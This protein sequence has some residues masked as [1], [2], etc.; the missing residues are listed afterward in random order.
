MCFTFVDDTDLLAL[1]M[2]D[3]SITFD[4]IA[5]IIQEAIDRWEGGLKTMDRAIVPQ[6]S[7]VYALDFNFDSNGLPEIKSVD[8]IEQEFYVLDHENVRCSLKIIEPNKGQETLGVFLDP[9][10]ANTEAAQ[11]LRKKTIEWRDNIK[12]GHISQTNT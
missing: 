1:N 11:Q 5:T 2:E 9:E 3:E 8:E 6:K 7:W 12:V 4:E 10:G